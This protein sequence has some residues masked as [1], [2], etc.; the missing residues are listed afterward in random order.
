MGLGGPLGNTF[1]ICPCD[2]ERS[3]SW[4]Q[5]QSHTAKLLVMPLK[6]FLGASDDQNLHF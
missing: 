1:F 5:G 4:G 2:L 3:R 6:V